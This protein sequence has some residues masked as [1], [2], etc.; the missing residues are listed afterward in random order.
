MKRIIL[1]KLSNNRLELVPK[2]RLSGNDIL[3]DK[4]EMILDG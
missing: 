1:K 2:Y 4:L 3:V